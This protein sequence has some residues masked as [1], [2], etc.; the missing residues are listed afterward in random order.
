MLNPWN[1]SRLVTLSF[2]RRIS[3]INFVSFVCSDNLL[4]D[5]F[6]PLFSFCGSSLEDVSGFRHPVSFTVSTGSFP[7]SLFPLSCFRVLHVPL[8]PFFV[9]VSQVSLSL[10]LGPLFRPLRRCPSRDCR[11]SVVTT[12][13]RWSSTGFQFLCPS[14]TI[15]RKFCK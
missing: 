2:C 4:S 11:E 5:M 1:L 14:T 9:Q 15:M 6:Y 13:F 12:L 7:L 3:E 10:L 8:C